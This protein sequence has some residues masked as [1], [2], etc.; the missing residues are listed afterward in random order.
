MVGQRYVLK[1]N[2]FLKYPQKVL[3][4]IKIIFNEGQR[5][6]QYHIQHETME[7]IEINGTGFEISLLRN[8]PLRFRKAGR[9]WCNPA[10]ETH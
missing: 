5:S 2:D 3:I 7:E 4:I 1:N 10:R 8:I 6:T 9:V